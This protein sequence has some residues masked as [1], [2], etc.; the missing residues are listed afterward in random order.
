VAFQLEKQLDLHLYFA[1]VI[2]GYQLG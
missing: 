1:L 2:W